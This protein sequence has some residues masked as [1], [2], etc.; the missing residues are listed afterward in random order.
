MSR[1]PENLQAIAKIGRVPCSCSA[2]PLFAG[3]GSHSELG[4]EETS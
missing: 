4:P 2:V 3:G 1:T